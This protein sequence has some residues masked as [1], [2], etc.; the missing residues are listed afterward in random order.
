[1]SISCYRYTIS[2]HVQGVFYRAST[3]RK[4]KSL[5]ITGTV[6]NL[7]DGGVEVVAEG[8]RQRLERLFDWLLQGPPMASVDR[9]LPEPM[10][11]QGFTQF[12]VIV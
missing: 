7:E 1:M 3:K 11:A 10:P 2:G 4:A 5:G 6:R 12:D 9:V 8:E